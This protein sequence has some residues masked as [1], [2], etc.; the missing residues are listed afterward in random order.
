MPAFDLHIVFDCADPDRVARFWLA[1]LGGYDFP[2]GVPAGFASWDEWA[3]ANNIPVDQ[4]NTGRTLVDR[5]RDRPDIFFLQVPEAKQVKNR[6]H[7][8]IKVAQGLDGADRRTAIEGETDRLVGLG[9][10][11]AERLD[12]AGGFH[13]IMR[14]PEGNEF[15]LA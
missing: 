13:V 7:L 12:E 6:V 2:F 1:A 10:T 14:D 5:D 15:C 8:D 4:R 3:D 9:A 11:V